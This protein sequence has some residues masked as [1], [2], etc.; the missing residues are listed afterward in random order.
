MTHKSAFVTIVGRPNVGKSTLI[1][2]LV[3]EKVA[4]TSHHPNTT[5][6]AIRGIIS[7]PEFQL[8]ITDTPGLHKPKTL[9]GGALNAQ[10]NDALEDVDMVI[11]CIPA[12]EEIGSG[13]EFIAKQISASPR[14]KKFCA[15]TKIDTVS[16]GDVAQQLIGVTSLAKKAGF[17]WSEII[18]ISAKKDIQVDLIIELL[19]A[20]ASEGPAFFPTEMRSDQ[21]RDS[22]IGELIREAAISELFEEVPHSVAVTVD[23]V[24]QREGRKLWDIHATI[25]VERDSQKAILI[26]KG[27]S[28]LKKIGANARGEIEKIIGTKIFL[29]LQVSVLPNWQ[30]D[31]KA[32][33]RLGFTH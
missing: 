22:I 20:H 6:S 31:P 21:E 12:N 1:N 15:V 17:E 26:G 27:G 10:V 30:S 18:P 25:L 16:R 13:D 5:R 2:A 7:R 24:S 33:E 28:N 29:G 23:D 9:L 4:I 3:G 14:T 8:V 11:L 32:L 19:A